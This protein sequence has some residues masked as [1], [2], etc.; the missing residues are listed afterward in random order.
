[1]LNIWTSYHNEELI[2]QYNL[3]ENDGI[4]LFNTAN[5]SLKKDNINYLNKYYNEMCTFYY[6][7][8]N[9]IYSDYVGFQLYRYVLT[10]NDLSILISKKYDMICE[11]GW[12]ENYYKLL[13]KSGFNDS[14][15]YK[16]I[17]F[18]SKYLQINSNKIIDIFMNGNHLIFSHNSF[19]CR[20]E[21]FDDLC[22]FI[23]G[24]Y[25][26]LIPNNY[27]NEDSIKYKVNL[28]EKMFNVHKEVSEMPPY[29][30]ILKFWSLEQS[31]RY[32]G[33]LTEWII[34]IYLA[35]KYKNNIY[36]VINDKHNWQYKSLVLDLKNNKNIDL[37]QFE[38]WHHKNIFSGI[39][40]IYLLNYKNTIIEKL[41][42]E[43]GLSKVDHKYV[44]IKLCDNMNDIK[45]L[46]KNNVY[47]GN[48]DEYIDVRSPF[49][50]Y[51]NNR[52]TIKKL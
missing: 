47:I 41:V 3:K 45:K 30:G 5:L 34:P 11:Y 2:N 8:K 48:I 13:L 12:Y 42:K 16:C 27:K 9:Y 6:I 44:Y 39:K 32:F 28:Y 50:F 52:Y 19:I 7:W 24:L 38:L 46:S 4:K 51:E 15:I 49:D 40:N 26:F 33:Y 14:I 31:S 35:I 18:I 10:C 20:W 22:T 23:F 21:I 29:D 36:N 17:L 25:D 43:N 1:M 37:N